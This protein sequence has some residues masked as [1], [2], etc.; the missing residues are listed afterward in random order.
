MKSSISDKE[1]LDNVDGHGK[2]YLHDAIPYKKSF[3]SLKDLGEDVKIFDLGR[4][5]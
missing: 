4:C 5:M 3:V 1:N 2:L